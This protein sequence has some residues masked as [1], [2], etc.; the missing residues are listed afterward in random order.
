[1]CEKYLTLP[2]FMENKGWENYHCPLGK[3]LCRC[4][5]LGLYPLIL[6]RR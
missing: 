5:G 2:S 6:P 4:L 1:M 3:K